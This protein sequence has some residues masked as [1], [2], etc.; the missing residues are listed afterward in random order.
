M[1]SPRRSTRIDQVHTA[2]SND[3]D[4]RPRLPT[5]VFQAQ[6]ESSRPVNLGACGAIRA[7]P[8]AASSDTGR[9]RRILIRLLHG[10]VCTP[11]L[12]APAATLDLIRNVDREKGYMALRRGQSRRRA[13]RARL[14]SAPM[15]A[16]FRARLPPPPV[17]W[18]RTPSPARALLHHHRCAARINGNCDRHWLRRLRARATSPLTPRPATSMSWFT[19]PGDPQAFDYNRWQPLPHL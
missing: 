5:P 11:S 7:N 15:R 2:T 12:P 4:H 14:I 16:A 10:S 9:G 6:Q 1:P 13:W 8:P 18:I 19:V 3:A 17:V